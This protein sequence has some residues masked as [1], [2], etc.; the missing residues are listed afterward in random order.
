VNFSGKVKEVQSAEDVYRAKAVIVATGSSARHLN[1]AGEEELDGKGVFYCAT[2]DA[3]LLR[4]MESRRAVVVGGGDSAL[5][6]ALALLPHADSVTVISRGADIRAKPLL[7]DRF[8]RD[9]K[10]EIL[11]ERSVKNIVGEEKVTGIT[12]ENVR[13]H[14]QEIMPVDAVFVGAGQVPVTEF[15]DGTLAL[16]D[17][18]FIITDEMLNASIP[19]VF[20]A[21]DVRVNPL[22]QIITAA[23]DGALAAHAAA[24]YLRMSST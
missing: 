12:L 18:G 10:A 4:T 7:V 23:A 19:G 8:T 24:Q 1:V 2:C 20:A 3:P 9:P 22:R 15:L 17:Q 21:G 13:S 11:L 5:H 16:D 6:T 14:E